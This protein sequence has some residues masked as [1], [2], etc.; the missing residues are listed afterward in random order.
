MQ[1]G[2]FP[3][4]LQVWTLAELLFCSRPPFAARAEI[5]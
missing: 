2:K 5:S 4:I 3:A 1:S